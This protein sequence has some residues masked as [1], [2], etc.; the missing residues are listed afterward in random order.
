MLVKINNRRHHQNLFV[1]FISQLGMIA[2]KLFSMLSDKDINYWI[3][4]LCRPGAR[5]AGKSW[6]QAVLLIHQWVNITKVQNKLAKSSHV[7]PLH[8][9]PALQELCRLGR[10]SK[11]ST[12]LEILQG[13]PGQVVWVINQ[14][15]DFPV[16]SHVGESCCG[17]ALTH[18]G[19]NRHVSM[20]TKSEQNSF[21]P[22]AVPRSH[23][24]GA[25]VTLDT[26]LFVFQKSQSPV[27]N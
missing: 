20:D 17:A 5:H 13:T 1:L 6:F 22:C 23:S 11:T 9:R 2:T 24:H 4:Q 27:G 3:G 18:E 15:N 10:H 16:T 26:G 14:L 19:I 25:L 12:E 7:C 8:L 21:P